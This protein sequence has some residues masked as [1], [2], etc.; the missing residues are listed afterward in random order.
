MESAYKCKE[1]KNLRESSGIVGEGKLEWT[2]ASG[3]T[4]VTTYPNLNSNLGQ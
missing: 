2:M 3:R 4:K 1:K